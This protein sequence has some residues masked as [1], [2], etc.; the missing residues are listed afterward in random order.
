MQPLGQLALRAA[1]A[2][3]LLAA[4]VFQNREQDRV[5]HLTQ[6]AG[7]KLCGHRIAVG[8]VE[9]LAEQLQLAA[10]DCHGDTSSFIVNPWVIINVLTIVARCR[11]KSRDFGHGFKNCL[12]CLFKKFAFLPP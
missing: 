12:H 3:W 8:L 1:P 10:G 6:A 5:P 11:K 9:L 7:G 4:I 2:V